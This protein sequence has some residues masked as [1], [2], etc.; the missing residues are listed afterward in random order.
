MIQRFFTYFT[1]LVFVISTMASPALAQNLQ[2]SA[3]TIAAANQS[4]NSDVVKSDCSHMDE[5]DMAKM[6][7]NTMPH[8]PNGSDDCCKQKCACGINHCP[9]S[10]LPFGVTGF[11]T[12]ATKI[13]K[14]G[15]PKMQVLA[16]VKPDPLKRPPRV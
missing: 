16:S 12:L 4:L 15:W 14:S 8:S 3:F 9:N 11:T 7:L 1:V 13:R 2:S 5:A 10:V 6:P